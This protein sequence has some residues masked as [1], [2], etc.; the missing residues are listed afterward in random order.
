MYI[1][2]IIYIIYRQM[3]NIYNLHISY[4]SSEWCSCHWYFCSLSL[5][6][7]KLFNSKYRQIQPWW[8]ASFQT[9]DHLL[10][11]FHQ[12]R[13]IFRFRFLCVVCDVHLIEQTHVRLACMDF[14][15]T[16]CVVDL[17]VWWKRLSQFLNRFYNF[18]FFSS[19]IAQ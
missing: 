4:Q 5:H 3:L 8:T 7:L 1:L 2:Y 11:E 17:P 9:N 15:H 14:T 18:F 10:D 6:F 19:R 16:H 13:V 12:N